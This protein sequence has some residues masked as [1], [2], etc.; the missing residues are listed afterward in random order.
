[1]KEYLA[2]FTGE[3][4]LS[5]QISLDSFVF[6]CAK[7]R[8]YSSVGVIYCFLE[9]LPFPRRHY[10]SPA[11]TSGKFMKRVDSSICDDVTLF[12]GNDSS[13]YCQYFKLKVPNFTLNGFHLDF[14]LID[15]VDKL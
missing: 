14:F 11:V 8:G 9:H 12:K 7:H 4:A 5:Q 6:G 13:T 10:L 3:S 1:L 15:H 2:F